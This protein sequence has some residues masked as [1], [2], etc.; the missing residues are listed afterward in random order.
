M[1]DYVGDS[2]WYA[3]FSWI[4]LGG[5]FVP[6]NITSLWLF[7]V[8]L[9]SLARLKKK[10]GERICTINMAQNSWNQPRMCLLRFRQKFSPT[11]TSPQIPK[12][13]HYKSRFSLKTRIYWQKCHQNSYSNRKQHIWTSE[14]I[15]RIIRKFW[16]K[17]KA[18]F[19]E[20]F[21]GRLLYSKM[22]CTGT[23]LTTFH[24]SWKLR[25]IFP[26]RPGQPINTAHFGDVAYKWRSM[27][28]EYIR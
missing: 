1:T 27:I 16:I 4:W 12:I 11:S 9:C 19:A 25:I 21:V 26:A 23:V 6:A 28:N 8:S 13:L 2:Y 3:N 22:T 18:F 17:S 10:A 20:D 15:C 5:E 14:L 24:E 7:V